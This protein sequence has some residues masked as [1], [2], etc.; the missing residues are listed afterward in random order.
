MKKLMNVLLAVAV[1]AGAFMLSGSGLRD[2]AKYD[3]W[4]KS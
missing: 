2:Y 4:Y 3:T 1:L